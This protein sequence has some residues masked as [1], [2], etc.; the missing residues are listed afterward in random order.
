MTLNGVSGYWEYQTTGTDLASFALYRLD[1]VATDGTITTAYSSEV[2]FTYGQGPTI[3]VS[4]PTANQVLATNTPT[5]SFSQNSTQVS[6]R[7]LIYEWVNSALG[8]LV[9]DSGSVSLGAASGVTVNHAV[10]SG[11]L[12]NGVTYR[13]IVSSTNNLSL[14]GTHAGVT[15]SVSF[16]LPAGPANYLATPIRIGNDVTP[17]AILLSWDEPA[18]AADK[19]RSTVV[20][21]RD[22][23]T[24]LSGALVL[25]RLTSTSQTT[26]VDYYPVSGETYTYAVLFEVIQGT[27]ETESAAAEADAS[28]QL[29]HVV[30]NLTTDGTAHVGLRYG[31]PMQLDYNDDEQQVEPWGQSKPHI[32]MGDFD[33]RTM[34]GTYRL[35]NDRYSMAQDD[36][37]N[38]RAI[39]AS[40]Q[41]ACYRDQFG[42]RLFGPLKLS[43]KKGQRE[44]YA[45]IVVTITEVDYQEGED[46]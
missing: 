40:R 43:E 8:T 32:F 39:R 4:S 14:T 22:S 16:P 18:Y 41:V 36:L 5:V 20:T 33:S 27:D 13:V 7:V 21:R 1:A 23:G 9:Y 46:S 29:E 3:T 30:I 45:D 44:S 12:H 6:Y 2:T 11:Y 35:V 34:K 37:N 31:E 42:D 38:V 15:F 25:A 10:P 26:F 28:V 17:S 19:F 24:P